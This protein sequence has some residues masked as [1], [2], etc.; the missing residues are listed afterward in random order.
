MGV[1][2]IPKAVASEL[3]EYLGLEKVSYVESYPVQMPEPV[4]ETATEEE[5]TESEE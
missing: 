2:L 4:V 3:I 1:W 5:V